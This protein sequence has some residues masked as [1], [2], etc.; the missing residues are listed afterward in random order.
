[1]KSNR[2]IQSHHDFFVTIIKDS[3]DW[4][5][6]ELKGKTLENYLK[7]YEKFP[8]EWR[9][10]SDEDKLVGIT[11]TVQKAPSNNKPWI[12]T[13][14]ITRELR[15]RGYAR[16]IVDSLSAEFSS[17]GNGAVF[18]SVPIDFAEWAT[19]LSKCLF[20]QYKIEED[21]EGVKFLLL[22]RPLQ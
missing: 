9:I 1:M 22:V 15:K 19:F 8:G 3:P 14:L 21:T 7:E 5:Q 18:T 11:Y 10:W 20:E 4:E 6:A 12:G 16:R 13:I 2:M 17:Q